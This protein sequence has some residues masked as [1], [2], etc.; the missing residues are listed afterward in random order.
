MKSDR[1]DL[2]IDMIICM[3]IKDLAAEEGIS[4]DEARNRIMSSKAVGDLYD[5]SNEIWSDGPD[6]FLRLFKEIG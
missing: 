2:T 3:A 1:L 6:A 4:E 5:E